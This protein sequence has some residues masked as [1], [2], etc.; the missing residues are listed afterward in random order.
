[1][2]STQ[3]GEWIILIVELWQIWPGPNQ[4]RLSLHQF[5]HQFRISIT[6]SLCHQSVKMMSSRLLR[7]NPIPRPAIHFIHTTFWSDLFVWF[8]AII[9]PFLTLWTQ[10]IPFIPAP[11]TS[12][13]DI[14]NS[15]LDQILLSHCISIP[16]HNVKKVIVPFLNSLFLFVLN[17][18][19]QLHFVW[20]LCHFWW[21]RN[22]FLW[23]CQNKL[24]LHQRLPQAL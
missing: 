2:A 3:R 16:I 6:S 14:L 23:W 9:S 21:W 1:M 10:I 22:I 13:E 19:A 5:Q 24:K 8:I 4:L 18:E 17:F 7:S 20:L 11:V 15:S 12:V